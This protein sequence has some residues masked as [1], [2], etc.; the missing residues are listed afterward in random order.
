M[1]ERVFIMTLKEHDRAELLRQAERCETHHHGCA[2]REAHWLNL[3]NNL[4]AERDK[5]KALNDE[6]R[7]ELLQAQNEL[8]QIRI[9]IAMAEKEKMEKTMR[10]FTPPNGIAVSEW[11]RKTGIQLCHCCDN[12]ACVDNMKNELKKGP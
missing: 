7:A 6:L 2:C 3:V 1:L 11:C 9:N 8:A 12:L 10:D 4:E 5:Y